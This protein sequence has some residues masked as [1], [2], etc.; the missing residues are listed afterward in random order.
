MRYD[1]TMPPLFNTRSA[2]L[3]GFTLVES[4]IALGIVAAM[5]VLFQAIIRTELLARLATHQNLARSI[6]SNELET[7][8]TGGYAALPASGSFTDTQ[9]SQL[10]SGTGTVTTANF[11]SK[12]KAVTVVVGW[13]EPSDSTS[14]SLSLSTLVTSVGGLK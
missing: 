8:R 14:R 1:F 12:T 9:L 11:N 5:L 4:V 13:R 7:L 2:L 6:A 3:R 10:P